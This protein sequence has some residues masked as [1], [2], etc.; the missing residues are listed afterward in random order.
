MQPNKFKKNFFKKKKK[1]MTLVTEKMVCNRPKPLAH[2]RLSSKIPSMN[3][4]LSSLQQ[5]GEIFYR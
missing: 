1:M 3:Q 4:Y 2:V 5:L